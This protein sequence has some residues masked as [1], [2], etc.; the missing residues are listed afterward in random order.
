MDLLEKME[1][2]IQKEMFTALGYTE[3]QE[4]VNAGPIVSLWEKDIHAVRPPPPIFKP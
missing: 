4:K 3:W 2:L 1:H